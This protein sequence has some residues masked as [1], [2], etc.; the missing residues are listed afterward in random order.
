MT[1]TGRPCTPRDQGSV[2]NMNKL[3]KR[4][5]EPLENEDRL[6]GIEPNWTRFLGRCMLLLHLLGYLSHLGLNFDHHSEHRLDHFHAS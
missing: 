3:V 4:V 5:I 2:E 1:V 6:N